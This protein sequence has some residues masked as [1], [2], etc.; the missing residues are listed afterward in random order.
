MRSDPSF[1]RLF[2]STR[3]HD[4]D[5]SGAPPCMNS[6]VGC[7]FSS[8]LLSKVRVVMAT[9]RWTH[10]SVRPSVM[11]DKALVCRLRKYF[12]IFEDIQ[13]Y[14]REYP[15]NLLH[16]IANVYNRSSIHPSRPYTT[17]LFPRPSSMTTLS[18][19]PLRYCCC[20]RG[21]VSAIEVP[22]YGNNVGLPGSNQGECNLLSQSFRS[23]IRGAFILCNLLRY[24]LFL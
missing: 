1:F 11:S 20:Q 3:V 8:L 17:N 6:S 19:V 2:W 15:K 23:V 10:P 14:F 16:P 24:I 22:S 9:D 12:S 13:A 21:S 4:N 7:F 18:R 5:R